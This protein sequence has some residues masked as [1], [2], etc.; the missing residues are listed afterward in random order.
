MKM[1]ARR[2]SPTAA[3]TASRVGQASENSQLL[4]RPC[5]EK[6]VERSSCLV[7]A[8]GTGVGVV[9]YLSLCMKSFVISSSW[10]FKALICAACE[11]SASA[12]IPHEPL[13]QHE[14]GTYERCN[15][16]EESEVEQA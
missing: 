5:G 6:K 15:A 16:V 14:L 8:L 1:A 13:Y 4:L 3:K 9:S 10:A 11:A 7:A 12:S 2:P